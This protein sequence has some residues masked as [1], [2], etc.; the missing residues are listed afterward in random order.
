MVNIVNER[1]ITL[2]QAAALLPGNQGK[3]L[4]YTTVYRWATSGRK[5][6]LLE[7]MWMGGKRIT[8][9]EAIQRFMERLTTEA[10]PALSTAYDTDIDRRL[11][12]AH[13]I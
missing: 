4:S 5:N 6:V 13:G 1:P 8:S 12:E 7:T 2:F 10:S 11:M 3:P 9:L